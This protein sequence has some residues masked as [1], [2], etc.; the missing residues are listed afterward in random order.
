MATRTYADPYYRDGRG[1]VLGGIISGVIAGIV[2]AMFA[3][4]YAAMM[5]M[6]LLT[7][8]RLIGATLF[9][10][11]ALIGGGIVLMASLIIHMMV[12]AVLGIIFAALL[13]RT[14]GA[15]KAAILGVVYGIVVWAVNTYI[16]LPIVNPTMSARI[17]IMAGAFWFEHVLFG[18][19]LGTAPALVRRLSR[20][21]PEVVGERRAA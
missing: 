17:P 6:G 1:I 9:G 11:D 8:L 14:A 3:M 4:G 13:P 19:F 12:S 18:A 15:G 20:R 21:P 7:P 16:T 5:G 2:M 10:V